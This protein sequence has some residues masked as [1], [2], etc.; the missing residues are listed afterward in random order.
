MCGQV[1]QHHNDTSSYDEGM[2]IH[3]HAT[4]LTMA[5]WSL[6]VLIIRETFTSKGLCTRSMDM[7]SEAWCTWSPLLELFMAPF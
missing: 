3:I 4:S 1:D 7:S 5:L 6:Y 2:A